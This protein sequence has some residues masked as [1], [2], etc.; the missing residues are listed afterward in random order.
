MNDDDFENRLRE[1]AG[2][3][4]RSDPTPAW[5]ADILARARRE[6]DALLKTRSGPPRWLVLS[7]AAV[8]VAIAAFAFATPRGDPPNETPGSH[9]TVSTDLSAV[10]APTLL[11]FDHRLGRH[12][13]LFP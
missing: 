10:D 9:A 5:R 3:P 7:W 6:A 1:L 2:Q 8:W 12:P 13:E 4:H 11:A